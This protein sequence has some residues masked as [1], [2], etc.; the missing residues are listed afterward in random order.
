MAAVPV[1]WLALGLAFVRLRPKTSAAIAFELGLL[2]A[3]ALRASR[4]RK[5]PEKLIELA[6]SIGDLGGFLDRR[7]RAKTSPPK[8]TRKPTAKRAP[9][10]KKASPAA[11]PRPAQNP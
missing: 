11:P 8:R 6:P 2:A 4:Q 1:N 9:R 7:R 5:I 10:V 3:Q